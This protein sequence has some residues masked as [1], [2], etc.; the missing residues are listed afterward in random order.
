MDAELKALE[1]NGTW[2]IETLPVRKKLVACKWIYKLKFKL[3]GSLE[4]YKAQLVTKTFTQREG[5]DFIDTFSPV[6]KMP[7]VVTLLALAD[8]WHLAELYINNTFFHGEL[9]EKVYMTF[10]QGY[11]S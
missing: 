7:T 11:D 6:A 2:T 1:K 8:N 4:R 3:D 5:F 9:K 10:P